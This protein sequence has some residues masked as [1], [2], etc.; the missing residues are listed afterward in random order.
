LSREY[1]VND[2]SM[3]LYKVNIVNIGHYINNN[4]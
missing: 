3:G 2:L 1:S 4:I